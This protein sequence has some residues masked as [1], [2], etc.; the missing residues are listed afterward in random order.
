[1]KL[2]LVTLAALM[3][4]SLGSYAVTVQNVTASDYDTKN[5][6]KPSHVVDDSN[7]TRWAAQ[8][9]ETWISVEFKQPETIKNFVLTSFKSSDRKLKFSVSYSLD[10]KAWEN[11]G[12]QYETT[13]IDDK[14]GEQFNF[15]KP[16]KAKFVRLNTFGTDVNKWSAILKVE[17]NQ[18]N[19]AAVPAQTIQN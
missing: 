13:L 5:G 4:L 8:G 19:N 11:A 10:G 3:S 9:K 12:G 6:H 14:T 7:S 18:E 16:I 17:F 1:M 15:K 2:K